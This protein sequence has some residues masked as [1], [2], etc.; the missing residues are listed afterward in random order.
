MATAVFMVLMVCGYWYTTRD[1]STRFKL[2]R[3]FGWDVYFLVALYGCIFVLQGVLAIAL[4]YLLLWGI[5]FGINHLPT[6][7]ALPENVHYHRDFINWSFLGIQ[8]PVVIMLMVSVMLCLFRTT[9]APG[10]RLNTAGRKRLYQQLTSAN[11]VEGIL[12]QCMERGDMVYITLNSHRVYIG[13]VHT[14]RCETSSTDNVV[15]IPMISGYRDRNTQ[16]LIVEHNYA[17]YYQQH[18][19]TPV[20]EP[21]NALNFR[22]VILLNQIESLSLFDPATACGFEK[23]VPLGDE[24]QGEKAPDER[25]P[26][27]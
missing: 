19:I 16:Q 9:W 12:Y 26:W 11:G 2:K 22:K 5:S 7:Y 25:V 13:M 14:A 3:T 17:A 1:I 20:S 10:L 4:V 15:V 24:G 6:L 8:A 21:N 27:V 23:W 18:W